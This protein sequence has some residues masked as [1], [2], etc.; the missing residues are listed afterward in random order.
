MTNEDFWAL[1]DLLDGEASPG[2]ASRL[3]EA[4]SEGDRDWIEGFA[5]Q[6]TEKMRQLAEAPLVGI[7]A[8]DVS[9]PAGAPA[10]PLLGDALTHFHFAVIAAGK[11]EFDQVISHP[12]RATERLWDF[13]ESDVLAEAV[14]A[15]YTDITGQP[16]PGPLPGHTTSGD[17]QQLAHDDG[18]QERERGPWLDIA[19]YGDRD[20]PTAYFDAAIAIAE[21]IDK[22]PHWRDWWSQAEPRELTIAVNYAATSGR[23]SIATRRGQTWATFRMEESRFRGRGAGALAHLACTDMETIFVQVSAALNMPIPGEIPRPANAT[24]PTPES[25]ASRERLAELRKRHRT[26]P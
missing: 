7:P 9:D 15:A 16:W 2:N 17:E 20:I 26:Q 6:L 23:S 4:L 18:A 24:P 14:A 3:T 13:S 25:V 12:E 11:P 21:T 8:G 1:I 22:D 19:L 5:D 10:V